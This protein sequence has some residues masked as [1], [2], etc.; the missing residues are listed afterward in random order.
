MILSPSSVANGQGIPSFASAFGISKLQFYDD[1]LSEGTI[2]VGNSQAPG[3]NW[4]LNNWP[5]WQGETA[6]DLGWSPAPSNSYNVANSNFNRLS[7][8]GGGGGA[9]FSSAYYV[10]STTM[11]PSPGG[12]ISGAK[13]LYIETRVQF[14]GDNYTSVWMQD[15]TAILRSINNSGNSNAFAEIALTDVEPDFDLNQHF[16]SWTGPSTNAGVLQINPS[17]PTGFNSWGCL[18]VPRAYNGGTGLLQFYAN[19]VASGSPATWSGADTYGA[20]ASNFMI[21]IEGSED[22]SVDY[23]AAWTAP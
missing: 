15:W 16:Y 20:E 22:I 7:G 9:P 5:G 19:R 13:P 14:N 3:F 17:L 12:F 10:N 8:T 2:D 4:Y 6:A 11:T 21:M 18:L 23:I 1:F